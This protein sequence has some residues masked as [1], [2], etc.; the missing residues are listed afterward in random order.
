MRLDY[1]WDNG[2]YIRITQEDRQSREEN[3]Q[4]FEYV[5]EIVPRVQ[6]FQ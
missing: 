4:L 5:K 3:T 6:V 1:T 2:E